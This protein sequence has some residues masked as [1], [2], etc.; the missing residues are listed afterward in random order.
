MKFDFDLLCFSSLPFL[1][2]KVL[3]LIAFKNKIFFI[4]I[5][6]D[7]LSSWRVFYNFIDRKQNFV[8]SLLNNQTTL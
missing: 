4:I 1:R 2:K 8:I 6:D 7:R 3:N 5:M